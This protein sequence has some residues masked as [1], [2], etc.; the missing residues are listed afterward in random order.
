MKKK[1]EN[2]SGISPTGHYILIL[3]DEAETKTK[4]GIIIPN[5]AVDNA[6][7]DT[8]QGIL[9]AVGP[10]GWE[11]FGD[12]KPWAKAGDKVLYGKYAGRD[13]IGV[14]GEKYILANC[15]DVLAVLN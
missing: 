13:M 12:G 7:R 11:E 3:P 2:K 15:E 6:K 8:T 1:T 10:I 5:E 14:D 9:I 4:G